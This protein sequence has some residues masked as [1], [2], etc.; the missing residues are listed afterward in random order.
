MREKSGAAFVAWCSKKSVHFTNSPIIRKRERD[1]N[2]RYRELYILK[3][4][5]IVN[6]LFVIFAKMLV[7]FAY[8]FLESVVEAIAKY[9]PKY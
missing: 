4:E 1:S 2:S 6:G 9:V 5:Y 7:I 3:D 8:F